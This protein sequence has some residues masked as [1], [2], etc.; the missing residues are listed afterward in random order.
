M[1]LKRN[2][3]T[4]TFV[5]A[6]VLSLTVSDG[7]GRSRRGRAKH[8]NPP[9]APAQVQPGAPRAVAEPAKPVAPEVAKPVAPAHAHPDVSHDA[10]PPAKPAAPP[11]PVAKP[12]VPVPAKTAAPSTAPPPAAKPALPPPP[13]QVAPPA[14]PPPPAAPVVERD[15]EYTD[16]DRICLYIVTFGTLPK[17]FITKAEA[18]RLGWQG[19]PLEPYAHGKSIGGDHY[20]NYERKLPPGNYRECDVDTRGRPR[21]AKRIVFS[22]DRRVYYSDDHYDTFKRLH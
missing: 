10:P 16:K 7:L 20:G 22:T 18:R 5:V 17:N 19:G 21:G 14:P 2:L 8:P 15:G 13:P 3:K 9:P 12:A 4:L 11:P 6:A 1:R